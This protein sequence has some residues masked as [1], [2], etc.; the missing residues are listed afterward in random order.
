MKQLVSRG[1]CDFEDNMCEWRH[2]LDGNIQW[3]RSSGGTASSF[4]GPD[5]DH[6]K[7]T[8]DGNYM[9]LE[10]SSPHSIGDHGVLVS[11]VYNP[12]ASGTVT[13]CLNFWYHMFGKD[14]GELSLY[15]VEDLGGTKTK[16]IAWSLFNEQSV[17]EKDWK[18]GAISFT[19]DKNFEIY[20]DGVVG[21]GYQGDIA[22]DDFTVTDTACT[23]QPAAAKP[24]TAFDCDFDNGP[25]GWRQDPNDDF[26]WLRSIGGT[27]SSDT[28][29]SGDHTTGSGFYMY[30]ETSF[31]RQ[32]GDV[33]M[34]VSPVTKGDGSN[35]CFSFWYHMFG[36][37][38][39]TLEVLLREAGSSNDQA[40]WR[41]KQD[42][43]NQWLQS[44]RNIG[45]SK[46][47]QIVLK[48]IRG[49][50]YESDIAIDDVKMVTGQCPPER[51]C[52]FDF[53]LCGFTQSSTDQLDWIR[54]MPIN[55][56]INTQA[57]PVDHSS[58]TNIGYYLYIDVDKASSATDKAVL[59]SPSYPA[60]A[61]GDCVQ[62]WY[63]L[64]GTKDGTLQIVQENVGKVW[65]QTGE[66]G[67]FWRLGYA[68]VIS[69]TA[70]IKVSIEAIPG[71]SGAGI[72]AIDDL[73]V[74]KKACPPPGSCD[75]E[76]GLCSWMNGDGDN[77]D[78]S[79]TNGQ[80]PSSTTGPKFDHTTM[81]PAGFYLFIEA[82]YHYKDDKANLNSEHFNPTDKACFQFWY[83][84][85]GK[86]IGELVV[87]VHDAVSDVA[88]E[89]LTISGNQGDEWHTAQV[90]ISSQKVFYLIMSGV[91]GH[92]YTS[93]VAIDD[94]NYIPGQKCIRNHL[95]CTFETDICSYIQV[96]SPDDDFDWTRGSGETASLNTGPGYDHTYGDKTGYYMYLETSPSS[97][98]TNH[99]AQLA[100]AIN[101]PTVNTGGAMCLTWWYHMYGLSI[102][103]LNVYIRRGGQDTRIWT[104]YQT[105]GNQWLKAM[106]TVTS[107]K[108][109]QVVWE[110]LAGNSFTGDIALDDIL[111]Y[112]GP[113]PP[114]SKAKIK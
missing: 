9:Y 67:A 26:D 25:C 46:D 88:E 81:T 48:G 49:G 57:P 27:P 43:G 3:L 31:P 101:E 36:S 69:A 59:E 70:Q 8:K 111:I 47:F 50:G 108:S 86:G 12:P 41:K 112:Y 64:S 19:S 22:L 90:D 18:N 54:D 11:G 62:F 1:D 4:T 53:D 52:D 89:K 73:E 15:K 91:I 76:D 97:V 2:S 55:V 20:I 87:Y 56:P 110:G 29:P 5:I 33:A 74:M 61:T 83:H 34:L 40:L 6:T 32:S 13:K 98:G 60:N 44:F 102:N 94:L 51:Y 24:S 95:N 23:V 77:F 93:D 68:T 109:W 75:F 42:Q 35:L 78:W 80:T 38:M 92:N 72:I 107:E 37:D 65:A 39:G 28:G 114:P 7:G 96:P 10:T 16:T 79:R 17:D 71:V 85:L 106:Y 113:C 66:Q 99:K 84:M 45:S 58:G 30:T 82:S 105:Q 103:R 63:Y 14:I 21:A 100:S 104:R